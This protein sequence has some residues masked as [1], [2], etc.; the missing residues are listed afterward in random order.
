MKHNLII[1]IGFFAGVCLAL[2]SAFSSQLGSILK[3]PILASI[4]TYS[5]GALFAIFF[6]VIFSNESLNL[7]LAKQV[8]WYL[9]F[10]GG[11]FSVTGITIYYFAFPIIGMGKMVAIGLCGQ[12]ILSVIAGHFGWLN[13]P[14]EPITVRSLFGVMAMMI[15]IYLITIK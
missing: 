6:V 8:P 14:I 10:I 2:Q 9:W 1:G 11:L 3:K 15:G 5:S 13:L 7:Q 4:S 12:L